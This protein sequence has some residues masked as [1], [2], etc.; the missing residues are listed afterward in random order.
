MAK[1]A[2]IKAAQDANPNYDFTGDFPVL[3]DENN[4]VK[5]QITPEVK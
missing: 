5:F 2:K 3:D 4:P 1:D